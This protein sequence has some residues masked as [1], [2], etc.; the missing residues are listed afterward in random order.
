MTRRLRPNRA[1]SISCDAER[2]SPRELEWLR[3][4][5]DLEE[6]L[7]GPVERP[8][9]RADCLRMSRPCGFLRCRHHLAIDINP[10]T[11]SIKVNFP[12]LDLEEMPET[13][14]LDVAGS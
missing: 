7:L 11:G 4:N 2:T 10:T 12:H 5:A 6:M 1:A 13:C 9:T 14:A 8:T 3:L